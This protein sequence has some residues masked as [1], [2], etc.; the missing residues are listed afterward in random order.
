MCTVIVAIDCNPEWPMLIAANRDEMRDRPTL[1]PA[2]HWPT[3]PDVLGG[4][5]VLAGGT[6]LALNASNVVACVLNRSGTL[7]PQAGKR[8]RGELPLLA[9]QQPTAA[10]AAGLLASQ[11]GQD[12]RSFNMVVADHRSAYFIRGTGNATIDVEA[13]PQGIHMVTAYDPND[14]A[15][16]RVA[17]H[18]P[19]FRKAQVPSPPDWGTWPLLLGDARPPVEAAISVAPIAGFGTVSSAMIALTADREPEYWTADL[20]GVDQFRKVQNA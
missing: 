12:W 16:P 4:L 17:R 10:R 7:G 3:Q 15:S 8:S 13:L 11:N 20:P 18:L 14:T 2:H 9:L 6:W 1:P 5:D 19:L